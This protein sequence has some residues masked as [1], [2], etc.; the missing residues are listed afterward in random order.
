MVQGMSNNESQ[1]EHGTSGKMTSR[2]PSRRFTKDRA[3]RPPQSAK[4]ST[5]QPLGEDTKS[6]ADDFA[7]SP[8]LSTTQTEQLSE[9]ERSSPEQTRDAHQQGRAKDGGIDQTESRKTE[10]SHTSQP[11]PERGG[12]LN[13]VVTNPAFSNSTMTKAGL[14]APTKLTSSNVTLATPGMEEVQREKIPMSLESIA[15]SPVSTAG[16]TL[17]VTLAESPMMALAV[18]AART[19]HNLS[20]CSYPRDR[21]VHSSILRELQNHGG[22]GGTVSASNLH[23]DGATW[24]KILDMGSS[25]H[26]RV[27]IFNML[28]YIGAWNWYNGQ[29][30]LAKTM[31]KTAKGK[32]VGHKTAAGQVLND[33][34]KTYE[35]SISKVGWVAV[36]QRTNESCRPIQ[37]QPATITEVDKHQRRKRITNQLSRGQKLSTKLV[38]DLGLGILLDPKIW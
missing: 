36:E 30:Q 13:D 33:I 18:Q 31:L 5:V 23:S 34:G 37:P 19:I 26:Q 15:S 38:K 4:I 10:N 14:D 16:I 35:M 8:L 21:N 9:H 20:K 25:E 27:T 1:R 29:I 32:P 2:L 3:Y 6:A 22:A 24:I 28:E 7:N 17:D 12:S 11:S